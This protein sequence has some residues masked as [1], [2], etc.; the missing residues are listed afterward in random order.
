MMHY[1]PPLHDREGQCQTLSELVGE[2]PCS[3][4]L[5][6]STKDRRA[7]ATLYPPAPSHQYL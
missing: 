6:S 1:L 5:P 2:H 4:L 7:E 3:T